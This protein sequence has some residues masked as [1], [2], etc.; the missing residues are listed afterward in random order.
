MK[1]RFAFVLMIAIFASSFFCAA[2]GASPVVTERVNKV[3]AALDPLMLNNGYEFYKPE[4]GSIY[5]I[6]YFFKKIHG[7]YTDWETWD[8]YTEKEVGINLWFLGEKESR[9]LFNEKEFKPTYHGFA[10]P[11]GK[12]FDPHDLDPDYKG[13]L[14]YDENDEIRD[15]AHHWKGNKK[16]N[17]LKEGEDLKVYGFL[18]CYHRYYPH[19]TVVDMPYERDGFV[20]RYIAWFY[21]GD[22]LANVDLYVDRNSYNDKPGVPMVSE[23]AL[24]QQPYYDEMRNIIERVKEALSSGSQLQV[25]L[26]DAPEP[27]LYLSIEASPSSLPADGAA[28]SVLTVKTYEVDEKNSERNPLAGKQVSLSIESVEGIL[29]GSLSASMVTTGGDGTASVKFTAPVQETIEG[30]NTNKATV[31]AESPGFGKDDANIQLETFAP[32]TAK[33]EHAILPAGPDFENS[34]SFTF[35]APGENQV[36]KEAEAVITVS[37]EQGRLSARPGD[38]GTGKITIQATPGAENSVYYHWSGDQPEEHAFDETVTVEIPSMGY[39][40]TVA[41]S[42]GVDLAITGGGP[43]SPGTMFPGLFVPFAIYIHD[44]FHKDA[45]LKALFETFG[46]EPSLSLVQTGYKPLPAMEESEDFYN[47][48]AAHVQ[49]VVQPG[50]MLAW[51]VITGDVRRAKDGD[52]I[53]VWKD[54]DGEGLTDHSFPGLVTWRR[55]TYELE[56]RLD[57]RWNGDASQTDHVVKLAPL[58][59]KGKGE[60]DVQLES[61]M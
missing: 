47:Q 22:V 50:D 30:K 20:C 18:H 57:P 34:I 41:F 38:A 46:P 25:T 23:T 37:G 49:G 8:I 58:S 61:F 39:S 3:K 36:G 10:E 9:E 29:P 6:H 17:L 56:A 21:V 15:P 14:L 26:P 4:T 1:C 2:V 53:L 7:N 12:V 13:S 32:L 5:H 35:G 40:G 59:I 33:A 45:D 11:F 24:D 52:W 16:I 19:N 42:V 51:D 43:L 28:S 48:L 55:G 54:Y 44:R 60:A 27:G 31:I